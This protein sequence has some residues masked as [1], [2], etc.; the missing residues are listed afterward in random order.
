[1]YLMLKN[2]P[3]NIALLETFEKIKLDVKTYFKV[4]TM[5]SMITGIFIYLVA[6][7]FGLDFAIFW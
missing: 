2:N 5:I 3:N 4:K 6:L 7:A 1:M